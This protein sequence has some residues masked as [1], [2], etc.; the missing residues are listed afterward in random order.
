MCVP[1]LV[2]VAF[3]HVCLKIN[4]VF[5]RQSV[6]FC[7]TKY[8]YFRRL[9]SRNFY[10]VKKACDLFFQVFKIKFVTF[11]MIALQQVPGSI[12]FQKRITNTVRIFKLFFRGFI[13]VKYM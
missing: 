7:Y 12:Y 6:Y 4:C 11:L 10:A 9:F 1:M 5:F 3:M 2:C 13:G 8:L